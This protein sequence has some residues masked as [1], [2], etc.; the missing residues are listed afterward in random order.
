[1][2]PTPSAA[3]PGRSL[4]QNAL[5]IDDDPLMQEM[6]AD[7]LR[8]A[9]VTRVSHAGDG[10]VGL[11]MLDRALT[12][13]V[14]CDLNMPGCDG[15]QFMEKLATRGYAGRVL[16]VSGMNARTLH[17]AELM[18]RF[19]RL[20]IIGSLSKPLDRGALRAALASNRGT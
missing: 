5:V 8:D 13:L 6:I 20:N 4:P 3:T 12:D 1:M 2:N 10:A 11:G 19:H 18:A 15:F 17:S 9:G 7:L 14:V 16:L